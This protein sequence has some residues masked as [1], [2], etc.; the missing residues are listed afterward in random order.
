MKERWRVWV[1]IN[2]IFLLCGL[3]DAGD[4]TSYWRGEGG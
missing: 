2:K 1:F 4:I 3:G